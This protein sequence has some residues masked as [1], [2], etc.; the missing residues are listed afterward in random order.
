MYFE[1]IRAIKIAMQYAT[2]FAGKSACCSGAAPLECGPLSTATGFGLI[3]LF[4]L[5]HEPMSASRMIPSKAT[6]ENQAM[7]DCPLGSTNAASKGPSAEPAFPPSWKSDC[8]MPSC[9][10]EAKRAIRDD[11]GWNTEDPM[12]TS[13]AATRTV[14]KVGAIDKIS[15]PI[16]VKPIPNASEY[17]L[18]R[19]S[20]STPTK[21]GRSNAVHASVTPINP[22]CRSPGGKNSSAA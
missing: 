8:A 19:W 13:A 1:N 12:P 6:S 11:S 5:A 22:P 2:F 4:L 15:R 20:V 3:D 21:G 17:G 16:K 14:P 7:L 10:P 18:A 9:P